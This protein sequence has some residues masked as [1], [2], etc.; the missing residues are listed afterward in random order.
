MIAVPSASA[1]VV[2]TMKAAKTMKVHR[3]LRKDGSLSIPM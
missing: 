1:Q 3:E 2:G